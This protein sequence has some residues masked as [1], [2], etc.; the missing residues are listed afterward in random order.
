MVDEYL[1]EREQAEQ[2]RVWL[3][4]NWIWMVAGVVL[5]VGGWYGYRWWQSSQSAK[6]LAAEVRFSAML[7][8]LATLEAARQPAVEARIE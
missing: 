3:R 1:S 5:V 2:L 7:D 4:D 6:S 8:A